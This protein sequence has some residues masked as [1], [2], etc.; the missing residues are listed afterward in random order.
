M[1]QNKNGPVLMWFRKDLRVQDNT[2]LFRAS[3]QA[4]A[5]SSNVVAFYV[6]CGQQFTKHSYSPARLDLILRALKELKRRLWEDF[7][8]PLMIIHSETLKKVPDVVESLVKELGAT[9]VFF[10]QE[11]EIDERDRDKKFQE[12]TQ[13]TVFSVDDECLIPPGCALTRKGNVY[14]VFTPFLNFWNRELDN[15]L[16]L[17]PNPMKNKKKV[18][19]RE[20]I[21]PQSLSEIQ[22]YML[23]IPQDSLLCFCREQW[24]ATEEEA[25][26]KLKLFVANTAQNYNETRNFPAKHGTSRL[27][28]YMASGILSTRQ[29]VYEMKYGESGDKS[30]TQGGAQWIQEL[31]WRD[32]YRHILFA[33]PKICKNRPLKEETERVKWEEP[34]KTLELWKQG[35]T[36]FPVVDAAMRQL[37][38]TGWMHNRL[39]MI[40]AVFLTKHLLLDWRHGELYFMQNLIDGDFASNNGGWQWCASTGSTS[41]QPYF[42]IFNPIRQSSKFDPDGNFIRQYVP[43]L[44]GIKDK[45]AI[46]E[47]F[48]HMGPLEFQA[49]SYPEPI[50]EQKFAR[51]RAINAFKILY[52]SNAVTRTASDDD[53]DTKK[54]TK[55]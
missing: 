28:A 22:G 20:T 17:S 31:A 29:C 8:I 9:H 19:V 11:Y 25:K 6:I 42:R 21:I 23:P 5:N 49:L 45:K 34:T 48:F 39:R 50:I 53:E 2:A 46:H 24:P 43:E 3:A 12:I 44:R 16:K 47:P 1:D 32:F 33:N 26:N 10:N 18:E 7:N 14:L 37:K 40:A 36:G 54:R 30:K 38:T 41:S 4:E 27:S 15:F 55:Y 52:K 35:K 13:V 51:E